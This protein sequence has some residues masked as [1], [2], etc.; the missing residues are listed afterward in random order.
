MNMV[1]G[2]I[3]GFL[4]YTLR[5]TLTKNCLPL[6]SVLLESV[7]ALLFIALTEYLFL[8]IVVANYKSAD[9]NYVKHTVAKAIETIAKKKKILKSI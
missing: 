1:Y 6:K 4:I 8:Q 2:C 9:P 5:V 7:I 3:G